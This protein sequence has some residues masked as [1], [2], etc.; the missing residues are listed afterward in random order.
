MHLWN[1]GEVTVHAYLSPTLNFH[2]TEGLRYAISID[3]APPQIVN[4]H[5]DASLKGPWKA[6][7]GVTPWEKSVANSINLTATT[8]AISAPGDH[9]LKYW[10]VDAGVVLQKLVVDTGGMKQSYLG[11]PE[12]FRSLH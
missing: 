1:S 9:V 3:D 7:D 4:I 2:A 10:M 6:A 11:P 5:W 8:H 12:S